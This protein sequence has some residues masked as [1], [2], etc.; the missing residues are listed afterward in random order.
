MLQ[1]LK[2]QFKKV[3]AIQATK[4]DRLVLRELFYL[5]SRRSTNVLSFCMQV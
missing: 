5:Q 2:V 4:T 1:T 3:E